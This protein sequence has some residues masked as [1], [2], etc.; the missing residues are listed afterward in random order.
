MEDI[1]EI[2]KV[3]NEDGTLRHVDCSILRGDYFECLHNKKEY[4][5]VREMNK[6]AKEAAAAAKEA[7][8]S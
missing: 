3:Y 8:K 7:E 2:A 4:S 1:P 5:R 6:R